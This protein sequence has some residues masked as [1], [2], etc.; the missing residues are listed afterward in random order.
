LRVLLPGAELV[1]A[2]A[3]VV[4]WLAPARFASIIYWAV[5]NHQLSNGTGLASFAVLAGLGILAAFAVR[6]HRGI[7]LS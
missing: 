6:R 5:G 2:L 4:H 1:S 7:R 3:P